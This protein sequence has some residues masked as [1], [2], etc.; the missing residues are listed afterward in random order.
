MIDS[1]SNSLFVSFVLSSVLLV[2]VLIMR[3]VFAKTMDYKILAFLWVLL[4]IRL[5]MPFTFQSPINVF[6]MFTSP[7]ENAVS[8]APADEYLTAD[9]QDVYEY[10]YTPGD[11]TANHNYRNN[12]V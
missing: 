4:L 9:Y 2:L 11:E 6:S 12:F 10:D 7:D 1:I 8:A 3:K 5:I